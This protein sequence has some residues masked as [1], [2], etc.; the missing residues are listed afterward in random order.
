MTGVAVPE[1][2]GETYY[3]LASVKPSPFDWKIA[4][5]VYVAGLA[6][7]SQI[8]ATLADRLGDERDESI[9]RNGR[10]VAFAGALIGAPL[11]IVDLKTPERFYNMLRIFRTS[12]PMSRSLCAGADHD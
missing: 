7:S 5:Y 2:S 9:V 10:A 12:S 8:I 4:T 6:G 11:L 3:G 1:W